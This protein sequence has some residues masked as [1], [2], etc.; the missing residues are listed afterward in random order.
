MSEG[1]F[2]EKLGEDTGPA[3]IEFKIVFLYV[4]DIGEALREVL[5][6]LKGVQHREVVAQECFARSKET[7]E[8]TA[9]FQMGRLK[10]VY[11]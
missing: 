5:A 3:D 4:M 9:Q 11:Y 6:L 1:E 8:V 10:L 7:S 2:V